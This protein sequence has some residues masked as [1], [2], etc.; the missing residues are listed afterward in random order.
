MEILLTEYSSTFV[1]TPDTEAGLDTSC[2]HLVNPGTA[3]RTVFENGVLYSSVFRLGRRQSVQRRGRAGRSRHTIVYTVRGVGNE[4]LDSCSPVD[5]ATAS[6]K[7][8][9][10]TG[11][12]PDSPDCKTSLEQFPRLEKVTPTTIVKSLRG[13]TPVL[14]LY[15]RNKDG[16]TFKEFGGDA[17]NFVEECGPDLRLYTCQ[18]GQSF[19]P[20]RDLTTFHDPTEGQTIES[21]KSLAEAAMKERPHL[22]A[23]LD[24]YKALDFADQEPEAFSKAIWLALKE[25][26]GESNLRIEDDGEDLASVHNCQ[27]S[28][29][30]GDLGNRAWLILERPGAYHKPTFAKG[31]PDGKEKKLVHR[32]LHFR[33]D[34]FNY[35][36]TAVLG[37]DRFVSNQKVTDLLY[38]HLKPVLITYLLQD[39]PK[40]C[41]NLHTLKHVQDRSNNEWF[42][43][44]KL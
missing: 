13:K 21:L 44:L 12:M 8:M 29:M 18:G 15:R 37:D 42:R 16:Q 40:L 22:V 28:Y 33:G 31:G 43:N 2:S 10:A 1:A 25:T 5:A 3:V 36:A 6:M 24:I 11:H 20:V 39:D 17:D 23:K 4:G 38:P 30:F 41:R 7:V 32:T 27:T 35:C 14:E 19:S 9:K 26:R 34:C